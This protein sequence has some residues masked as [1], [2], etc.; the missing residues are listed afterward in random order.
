MQRVK[1]RIKLIFILIL[2][3]SNMAFGDG[4]FCNKNKYRGFY[5]FEQIQNEENQANQTSQVKKENEEGS[6]Y[7][8]PS[9]EEAKRQLAMQ[10]EELDGA[11]D[12]MLA[13]SYDKN[14]PESAVRETLIAYKKLENK[15]WES[16]VR[17]AN[18]LDMSNFIHPEMT[19]SMENPVNVFAA[20][21]QRKVEAEKKKTEIM[22]FANQ[23]DLLVFAN[24]QCPYSVKFAPV[25]KYFVQTY[26]FNLDITDLTGEAGKKA[27]SLGIKFTPTLIA[28]KKDGSEIFELSRGMVSLTDL[29]GAILLAKEYMKELDEKKNL[30]KL[31]ENLARNYVAK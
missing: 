8:I 26:G 15:M 29:E 25:L 1:T 12:Q 23:F 28:I 11:R 6:N 16:S 3:S 27:W 10:K 14:A 4:F 30:G 19:D 20:K 5:W 7:Q 24:D 9:K 18:G 17:L 22:E 31:N 13:V 21:L 2:F